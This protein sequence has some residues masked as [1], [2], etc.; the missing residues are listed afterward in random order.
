[1][2]DFLRD[3]KDA[4]ESRDIERI[5]DLFEPGA[6]VRTQITD[7][8]LAM[9]AMR[10]AAR[11]AMAVIEDIVIV[12]RKTLRDTNEAAILADLTATFRGDL[13][14]AGITFPTDG[15][16]MSIEAALFVTLAPDGRVREMTRVRDNWQVMR[17]LGIGADKMEELAE[18]MQKAAEPTRK[19]QETKR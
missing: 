19:K 1:M 11:D 8:P 3:W 13:S 17:Q 14:W 4:F 9:D 18:M 5:V 16:T 6:L 7:Q 15:R 12:P 10:D 2:P